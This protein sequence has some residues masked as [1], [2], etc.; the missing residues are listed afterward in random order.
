MLWINNHGK[1]NVQEYNR[2]DLFALLVSFYMFQL[3]QP[4]IDKIVSHLFQIINAGACLDITN[5]FLKVIW[6]GNHLATF[7]FRWKIRKLYSH[8]TWKI[9]FNFN[10]FTSNLYS[11]VLFWNLA[12]YSCA[13]IFYKI[14]I[15]RT[16][17]ELAIII[18]YIFEFIFSWFNVKFSELFRKFTFRIEART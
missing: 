2:C 9:N 3:D 16:F 12:W 8:S 11:L 6:I 1:Y 15:F 18:T 7:R 10:I 4:F 5:K 17:I 13:S 14:S